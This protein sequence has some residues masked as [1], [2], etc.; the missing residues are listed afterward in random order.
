MIPNTKTF[1]DNTYNDI[2]RGY[3]KDITEHGTFEDFNYTAKNI[4]DEEYEKRAVVYLPFGYDPDDKETKY[5]V[6][7]LM[8]GGGDNE[9]RYW[10]AGLEEVLDAMFEKGDCEPCIVVTP[11]YRIPGYDETMSAKILCLSLM[12]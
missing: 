11:N 5:N 2:P 1:P 3:K 12:Q 7:Y 10:G 6:L 9:M 8:H 4:K